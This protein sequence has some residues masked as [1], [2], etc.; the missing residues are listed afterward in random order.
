MTATVTEAA[1]MEV[2]TFFTCSWG[3]DQ[4][5]VDFYRVMEVSPSGK[6][7]KVQRWQ[8]KSVAGDGYHDK[9]VPGDGPVTFPRWV[10]GQMVGQVPSGIET[11]RLRPDFG[12]PAF[13][14][15]S[16]SAAYIWDGAPKYQTDSRSGH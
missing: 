16:Y 2:G 11:R 14:V 10:D 4:T 3:Y 12:R 15:N 1:A 8:A 6:T 13:T 9:L 7:I 5:N